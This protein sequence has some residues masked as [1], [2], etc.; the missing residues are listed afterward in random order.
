MSWPGVVSPDPAAHPRRLPRTGPGS[1]GIAAPT[2]PQLARILHRKLASLPSGSKHP[3]ASASYGSVA[4]S[5]QVHRQPPN[6]RQ[7]TGQLVCYLTRTTHVLT[8]MRFQKIAVAPIIGYMTVMNMS[9][10]KIRLRNESTPHL[11][12]VLVF[13]VATFARAAEQQ[14][15][16]IAS[17]GGVHV[18]SVELAVTD[19]ERARGLM[20]R[21]SVCWNPMG[22]CSNSSGNRTCRCGCGTPMCPS[23]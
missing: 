2:S 8:T 6:R 21:R 12:V 20:F 7:G 13:C 4:T 15:L 18:F 5:P 10:S 9:L 11:A 17:K 1:A 22:C 16:E 3:E 23:T 19:E 14:T